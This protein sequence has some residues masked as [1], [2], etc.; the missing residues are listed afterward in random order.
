MFCGQQHYKD[1][2]NVVTNLEAR[3]EIMSTNKF[4]YKCVF[5][6][7]IRRD[8]R[9]KSKCYSCKAYGHNTA[10]CDKEKFPVMDKA[11]ENATFIVNLKTS[12]LLQ[13]ATATL[14]DN[15]ERKNVTVKVS[16][17]PGSQKT[18]ISERIVK[19]LN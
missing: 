5:P 8:C 10:I 19:H 1:K 2:C 18:Y 4:C 11:R 3:K 17:D 14:S 16:M 13:T 6:G 7:H 12:V 15:N 9:S